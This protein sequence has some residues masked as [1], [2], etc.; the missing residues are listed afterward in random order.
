MR[1]YGADKYDT[2]S[3]A[4][5]CCGGALRRKRPTRQCRRHEAK[6]ARHRQRQ[7]NKRLSVRETVDS[8]NQ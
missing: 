4:Y 6:R 5:G 2:Q 8:L 1:A 7:F 3:C